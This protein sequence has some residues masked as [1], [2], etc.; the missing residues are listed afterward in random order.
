M[1]YLKMLSLAALAA[2]A[3]SAL[4]ASAA[5]ANF[6]AAEAG[7]KIHGKQTVKHV[8]KVEGDAVEC[9]A[10]EFEGP[11]QATSQETVLVSATYKE[12]IAFGFPSA[13]VNMNGCE[14]EFN[15]PTETG[16]NQFEGTTSLV[17]PEG[18][19]VVMTAGTCEAKVPGYQTETEHVNQELSKVLYHNKKATEPWKVEVVAELSGIRV[20]KAKDGFLCQFNGTGWTETGTYTGTTLMEGQNSGGTQINIWVE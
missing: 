12:C 3:V 2:M 18:K 4:T 19:E 16:E 14:Y 11:I 13:T 10:A 5:S 17:C 6:R 20:L 7:G 15:Q 9:K 8:F 1:R